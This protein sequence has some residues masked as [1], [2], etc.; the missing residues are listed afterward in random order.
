MAVRPPPV[1]QLAFKGNVIR[2]INKI[3]DGTASIAKFLQ[4]HPGWP[5]Q[6]LTQQQVRSL[7]SI[8]VTLNA[9]KRARVPAP[10]PQ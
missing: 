5:V 7:N 10:P 2:G 1:G 9:Q 4:Q 6:L 3:L 8:A